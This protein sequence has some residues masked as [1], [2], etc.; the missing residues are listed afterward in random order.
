MS[1]GRGFGA[2][3]WPWSRRPKN[4]PEGAPG[5]SLLGT[6]ETPDLSW[7]EEAHRLAGPVPKTASGRRRVIALSRSGDAALSPSFPP[8]VNAFLHQKHA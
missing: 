5:P 3:G 4:H 6:G 7:Q 1:G 8:P 2:A